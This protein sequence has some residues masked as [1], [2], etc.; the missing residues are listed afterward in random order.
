MNARATGTNSMIRSLLAVL[1]VGVAPLAAAPA[2]LPI[3]PDLVVAV[4]GSGQ[5][6]SIHAAVQSIPRENRERRVILIKNGVYAEKV[7]VD[8][9]CLTLRGESRTGTRI[10]FAQAQGGGARDDRGQGV[11]NLTATAHD[12]VIE[13]LTVRNTHGQL[14]IHAFAIFGRADRT[15]IQDC[16]VLSHGNDTLSLWRGRAE[17]AATVAAAMPADDLGVL[18]DGGRYYHTRLKVEGSVDFICPRG[19]CYLA[20]SQITQLNPGATAGMWHD[21][22]ND[23]D[24]K[25]VLKNCTFDGPPNWYLARRHHDG[26]FYFIDC[27]F[28]A[29]MRDQPPY[30]QM[31]PLDGGPL[32]PAAIERNRHYDRTNKFGDRNYFF[33]SRRAGGDYAWHQ[34][35]LATAPGA[36]KPEQITAKWTFAG[37]WDP[38]RAAPR[39]EKIE[40]HEG[41]VELTF[42]ERV[43]VKGRP[44]LALEQDEVAVYATGSGTKTLVFGAPA[45]DSAVVRVA[46]DRGA[47]VATEAAAVLQMADLTL[48]HR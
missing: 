20:D 30:R 39:I 12:C 41:R 43:T 8:A 34:D 13:N 47:I 19:W 38:E 23:P 21:G 32:T 35:N 14:G 36:P 37:T 15:V 6:T 33:N 4:D 46:L 22:S 17:D 48:P 28:S 16:D 40:L 1:L 10:E 18:Q 3:A 24:K 7:R 26:Q 9:A 42:S 11:L 2:P 5:F 31:Y 27:K 25:F 29:T 44:K 45:G